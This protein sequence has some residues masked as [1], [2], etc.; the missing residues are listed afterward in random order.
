MEE[1]FNIKYEFDIKRIHQL[2]DEKIKTVPSDYIC[3]ADGNV[4]TMAY[5]NDAYLKVIN[6]GMFSLCDSSWVPVFIRWIYGSDIR[7]NHYCGVQILEDIIKAKKYRMFFMGSTS[8]VLEG[9][10][11]NIKKL[12]ARIDDMCFYELPFKDVEDFDYPSIAK[13][14]EKDEADIIW[15]SLGAPKQEIFMNRLKPYLHRGVMISVG[16][17]FNFLSNKGVKRAPD[18]M[19][20]MHLEFLHRIFKEPKKQIRRCWRILKVLPYT[21]YAEYRKKHSI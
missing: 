1:Y 10:K 4:L 18:W 12:D 8:E 9:L 2:I 21:L 3:V 14:I 17:A 20:R 7:Y 15:V 16:A 11:Q 6:G 5:R 19:L 13:M